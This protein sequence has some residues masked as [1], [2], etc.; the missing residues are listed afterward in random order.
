M[1]NPQPT[2]GELFKNTR[3]NLLPSHNIDLQR[4]CRLLSSLEAALLITDPPD[5]RYH[6]LDAAVKSILARRLKTWYRCQA[7][8]EGVFIPLC[9][10]CL[11]RPGYLRGRGSL[12]SRRC[13]EEPWW[14]QSLVAMVYLFKLEHDKKAVL[15]GCSSLAL[16]SAVI[17]T[18]L[19]HW[20]SHDVSDRFIL[21]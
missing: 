20:G 13:V 2:P 21:D 4:A 1:S 12:R 9:V 18:H 7:K 8:K 11:M 6:R 3:Y 5:G 19:K 15:A 14:A 17:A 10:R 16:P